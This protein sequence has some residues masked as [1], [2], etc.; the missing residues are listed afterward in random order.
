M[1]QGELVVQVAKGTE[2]GTTVN[3]LVYSRSGAEGL[4]LIVGSSCFSRQHFL[5]FV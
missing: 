3:G 5:G 4:T 1:S 2:M